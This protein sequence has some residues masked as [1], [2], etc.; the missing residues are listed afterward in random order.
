LSLL[1]D[2]I[3]FVKTRPEGTSF[4]EIQGYLEIEDKEEVRNLITD[5]L[6]KNYL[7]K[8]GEKRG[9]RYLIGK[10]S[11][12]PSKDGSQTS[13]SISESNNESVQHNTSKALEVYLN[14]TTPIH[15]AVI[16]SIQNICKFTN[17]KNLCQFIQN[18]R[19]IRSSV[20]S[21]DHE[22]KKNVIVEQTELIRMN[23][24]H[25]KNTDSICEI[26]KFD[27]ITGQ[28]EILSYPEYEELRDDLRLQLHAKF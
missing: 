28:K 5:S 18:G 25:I 23:Y 24:F 15:G 20:I 14:D 26:V 19:L 27:Q 10:K 11:A 22:Q 7:I 17:P 21:Y 4:S 12:T 2:L 13:D 16:T 9:T 8:T 6:N 1:S 3:D